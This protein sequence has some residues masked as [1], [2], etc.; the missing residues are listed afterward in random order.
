MAPITANIFDTMEAMMGKGKNVGYYGAFKRRSEHFLLTGKE[1]KSH[2]NNSIFVPEVPLE[3][4][5]ALVV[6]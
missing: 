3:A 5:H 6:N 4:R 1:L 2:V